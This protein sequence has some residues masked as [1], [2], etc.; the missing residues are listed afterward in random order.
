[1][2]RVIEANDLPADVWITT[3]QRE[4]VQGAD[5]VIT[6]FQVGG[7]KGFEYDYKIP[8]KHGVD[9][10]IGDTLGP[11]GIFRALRTIPV[12]VDVA[13]DM[14]QVCPAAWL[15]DVMKPVWSLRDRSR[16][17]METLSTATRPPQR[18]VISRPRSSTASIAAQ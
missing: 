4:A 5:Y 12:V 3:D 11:G 13:R 1:M 7:V 18:R 15:I 17:S 10:C 16:T 6:T 14:E 2:Q 9:Q 8:F